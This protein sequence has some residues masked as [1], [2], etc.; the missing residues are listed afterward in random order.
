MKNQERDPHLHGF[1]HC[2]HRSRIFTGFIKSRAA[3][4]EVGKQLAANGDACCEN[5][6]AHQD[7]NKLTAE[8]ELRSG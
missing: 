4:I 6:A 2:D 1:H 8:L 5:E 7:S 3:Y